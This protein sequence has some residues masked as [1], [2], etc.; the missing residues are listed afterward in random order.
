MNEEALLDFLS[1]P[2]TVAEVA[3]YFGVPLSTAESAVREAVE[4]GKVL[5]TSKSFMDA[6]ERPLVGKIRPVGALSLSAKLSGL[7]KLGKLP[8][9]KTS[10]PPSGEEPS[11][12]GSTL[13]TFRRAEPNQIRKSIGPLSMP[14]MIGAV[15]KSGRKSVQFSLSLEKRVLETLQRRPKPLMELHATLGI[16]RRTLERFVREGLVRTVWGPGGIGVS[17]KL[18]GKGIRELKE[19]QRASTLDSKWRRKQ[20][21]LLKTKM[22]R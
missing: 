16:S 6:S 10:K 12:R 22:I 18:T 1:Q 14:E 17:Y 4:A 7:K 9:V 2:R 3:K 11:K 20:L 5:V 19:L 13:F 21:I 15:K 8:Q